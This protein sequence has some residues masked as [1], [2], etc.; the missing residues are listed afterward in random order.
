MSQFKEL[1]IDVEQSRKLAHTDIKNINGHAALWSYEQNEDKDEEEEVKTLG[2]RSYYGNVTLGPAERSKFNEKLFPVAVAFTVD[3]DK[4][5]GI[6]GSH[7]MTLAQLN[8]P[9][10]SMTAREFKEFQNKVDSAR[11]KNPD[12]AR[13]LTSTEPTIPNYPAPLY[14][15]FA[16]GS[17]TAALKDGHLVWSDSKA[18]ILNFDKF[19]DDTRVLGDCKFSSAPTT[20]N[21]LTVGEQDSGLSTKD[22]PLPSDFGYLAR[23]SRKDLSW[24]SGERGRSR[25]RARSVDAYRPVTINHGGVPQKLNEE[26]VD[27]AESMV[28]EQI[29]QNGM[30][31]PYKPSD[32]DILRE[33][34][35]VM[36]VLREFYPELSVRKIQYLRNRLR[37]TKGWNVA[38][39]RLVKLLLP[40]RLVYPVGNIPVIGTEIDALD[41]EELQKAVKLPSRSKDKPA[42]EE[43]SEEQKKTHKDMQKA[44]RKRLARP[45]ASVFDRIDKA[46]NF[47]QQDGTLIKLTLHEDPRERSYIRFRCTFQYLDSSRPTEQPKYKADIDLTFRNARPHGNLHAQD[48][49]NIYHPTQRIFNVSNPLWIPFLKAMFPH[50]TKDNPKY[51]EQCYASLRSGHSLTLVQ[52]QHNERPSTSNLFTEKTGMP[53]A[54]D[55]LRTIMRASPIIYVL[56]RGTHV[57]LLLQSMM[58]RFEELACYDPMSQFF[59]DIMNP[60]ITASGLKETLFLP[61][62]VTLP[63]NSF[64][65]WKE[66]AL[67]FGIGGILEQRFSMGKQIHRGKASVHPVPHTHKYNLDLALFVNFTEED[68]NDDI[69]KLTTGDLVKVDFGNVNDTTASKHAWKGRVI[70]P[71]VS[72]AMGQVCMIIERPVFQS[73]IQDTAARTS[74]KATQMDNMG[75]A[76][77]QDWSRENCSQTITV[78]KDGNDKE[79]KR[80]TNGLQHMIIANKLRK[81]FAGKEHLLSQLRTMM[82][83]NDHANYDHSKLYH[84][85]HPDDAE[86]YIELLPQLL[87]DY[88]MLPVD[89][90]LDDGLRAN[91]AILAGISGSGK[92]YT[93]IATSAGYLFRVIV[94]P[95]IRNMQLHE[96]GR[97]TQQP[98]LCPAVPPEEDDQQNDWNNDAAAQQSG[99]WDSTNQEA[100]S[101]EDGQQNAWNNDAAA[102][103]SGNWDSTNQE[104]DSEEADG[105]DDTNA[106][107]PEDKDTAEITA[108]QEDDKTSQPPSRASS[109]SRSSK[110]S[111]HCS[112]SS[113]R[114]PSL[115]KASSHLADSDDSEDS[116]YDDTL[117][118]IPENS[119]EDASDDSE[120]FDDDASED[121]DMEDFDD[122]ASKH[123]VISEKPKSDS[124]T[125]E[126]P[127]SDSVT[128][129]KP[130]SDSALSEASEEPEEIIE[131][132]RV[133][134]VCIQ[135]ETVD[136]SYESWV[137]IL[138]T[139]CDRLGVARKLVVRCHS[140]RSEKKAFIAMLDPYFNPDQD[141]DQDQGND[142]EFYQPN[143]ALQGETSTA[144][145]DAYLR[146]FR[147]AY[148][149]ISDK[150]FRAINGSVAYL[151]MQLARVPTWTISPLVLATWSDVE[152]DQLAEELHDVIVI[153]RDIDTEGL[154][155]KEN[156]KRLK[157]LFN[158]A[159]I[160]ILARAPVICTTASV[161]T[162]AGFQIHR[163][164]VAVILEEAGRATDL[165]FLGFMSMYWDVDFRLY[166]G[167]WHQLG[168]QPFGKQLDNPFQDQ[169]RLSTLSRL[170]YTG[171]P[172]HE[173][174]YTSRFTNPALLELCQQLNKA[175]TIQ[176]V[177]DAFKPKEEDAVKSVNGHLWGIYNPIVV[178]N[179][180]YTTGATAMRDATGSW[181]CVATAVTTMH[182]M[183]SRL[184]HV[185]GNQ[186]LVITPYNAQ[187]R[188]LQAFQS[189]AVMNA[190]RAGD[191]K[192]AKE[193]SKVP[194]LTVD[195]S[196]GKD[197]QFV[198]LDTVNQDRGFFWQQ[199][200]TLVAGTRARTGFAFVGSTYHLT[201]SKY[202]PYDNRLKEALH[203]WGPQ[204][205]V[206][207]VSEQK[208]AT[209]EQYLHVQQ[210]LSIAAVDATQIRDFQRAPL[211][212]TL[213]ASDYSDDEDEDEENWKQSLELRVKL[214]REKTVPR[215]TIKPAADDESFKPD[216]ES[217]KPDDESFKPDDESFKPDDESFKPDA[218]SN[219]HHKGYSAIQDNIHDPND[220]FEDEDSE[221][222]MSGGNG[223]EPA[224]FEPA[225]KSEQLQADED[226]AVKLQCEEYQIENDREETGTSGQKEVVESVPW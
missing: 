223:F 21:F 113:S 175:P 17:Q 121:F 95:E 164:A 186:L 206:T 36:Q 195:S 54:Y 52:L 177:P 202:I 145:L 14:G 181:Y 131:E 172:I 86:R 37:L 72:T 43:W 41:R 199:P 188:V 16:L 209:F 15:S 92:S 108:E 4:V 189:A 213:K 218:K 77:M 196:M 222:L 183:T 126:K 69:P 212:A 130:K 191:L 144:L 139:I 96:Y 23:A 155:S 178:I 46:A 163:R 117:E 190:M 5:E 208:L 65:D 162:S 73:K 216:D 180:A 53:L 79:C 48:G 10:A 143:K 221:F 109:L 24:R 118:N 34:N 207:T 150:R 47:K 42:R 78:F 174:Q 125:S 62:F 192:L 1:G 157:E 11:G 97:Y 89:A 93:S 146:H 107:D 169:L 3:P 153:M 38:K 204:G 184:R 122:G 136:H 35:Y 44:E 198:I 88:Q 159:Y 194:I 173:L 114:A 67:R 85:L 18:V 2:K 138:A 105:G 166:V 84:A 75:L 182:D 61:K 90:W 210:A 74:L 135:N 112:R 119:D 81:I 140:V 132:G 40:Q 211:G 201:S 80:L 98:D 6:A 203:Q 68:A 147:S 205:I 82:M 59:L 30:T 101:G 91:T 13:I 102:Q 66:A 142:P 141:D 27:F 83:C 168:P 71:T 137:K 219:D 160:H 120:D 32:A 63:E 99:N 39:M 33:A 149:G 26:L 87:K 133:T 152:L 171:F 134:H 129:E 7:I 156:K 193:I 8:P 28:A 170:Y 58:N 167:D 200:R 215:I 50:L 64:E 56:V 20:Y 128:S 197:A 22:L 187:V 19:Q 111:T 226:L 127:K 165:E 115:S 179:V 220:G 51:W 57:D 100:D 225:P 176:E 60:S 110:K 49:S 12:H 161:A 224:S 217:F 106:D 55:N 104:A 31:G 76:E 148:L 154:M 45:K 103:Q 9:Q 214:L 151:V 123:S 116:E 185:S 70:P 124:V 158:K 25:P 94:D 29:R